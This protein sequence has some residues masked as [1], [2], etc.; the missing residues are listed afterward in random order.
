M[1]SDNMRFRGS[2]LNISLEDGNDDLQIKNDLKQ[3]SKMLGQQTSKMTVE[4]EVKDANATINVDADTSKAEKKIKKA[5]KEAEKPIKP[6]VELDLPLVG[7]KSIPSSVPKQ[8]TTDVKKYFDNINKI[9]GNIIS[10]SQKSLNELQNKNANIE[11]FMSQNP[12]NEAK[13]AGAVTEFLKENNI[14]DDRREIVSTQFRYGNIIKQIDNAYKSGSGVFEMP[15]NLSFSDVTSR[16]Q[17]QADVIAFRDKL[18]TAFLEGNT[19]EN[20]SG[21]SAKE[22]GVVVKQGNYFG[23]KSTELFPKFKS[24]VTDEISQKAMVPE[25]ASAIESGQG[26]SDALSEAK[27]VIGNDVTKIKNDVKK[28]AND[29]GRPKKK[30]LLETNAGAQAIKTA[31]GEVSKAASGETKKITRTLRDDYTPFLS[32]LANGTWSDEDDAALGEGN[33]HTSLSFL[34]QSKF[35]GAYLTAK[36]YG[37]KLSDYGIKDGPSVYEQLLDKI[38]ENNID[39][40]YQAVRNTIESELDSADVPAIEEKAAKKA[41]KTSPKKKTSTPSK[42]KSTSSTKKKSTGTSTNESQPTTSSQTPKAPRIKSNSGFHEVKQ[43]ADDT[44]DAIDAVSSNMDKA[45]DSADKLAEQTQNTANTQEEA[46]KVEKD[47]QKEEEKKVSRKEEPKV[48]KKENEG[49]TEGN[50]PRSDTESQNPRY[51]LFNPEDLEIV[52][53]FISDDRKTSVYR[54]KKVGTLYTRNFVKDDD[55]NWWQ[56]DNVKMN[57]AALE[58]EAVKIEK[59]LMS[60]RE[61]LADEQAKSERNRS[62]A[63]INTST[64]K[65][66]QLERRKRGLRITAEA[67]AQEDPMHYS[68]EQ[69]DRAVQD[70]VKLHKIDM[71]G[72]SDLRTEKS[73]AIVDE[74]TQAVAQARELDQVNKS[75]LDVQ[76]QIDDKSNVGV[77]RIKLKQDLLDLQNQRNE[78]KKNLSDFQSKNFV[79]ANKDVLEANGK[80]VTAFDDAMRRAEKSS[81]KLN[82]YNYDQI[83]SQYIELMNGLSTLEQKNKELASAKSKGSSEDLVKNLQ[84]EIKQKEDSLKDID[85][86]IYQNENILGEDRVNALNTQKSRVDQSKQSVA[87]AFQKP[88]L[89]KKTADFDSQYD[90]A[91]EKVRELKQAYV[92]LYSIQANAASGKYSKDE[93]IE[94]LN[95]QKNKI[96]DIKKDVDGFY[97]QIYQKN[98]S[99]PNDILNSKK[100]EAYEKAFNDMSEYTTYS[101]KNNNIIELMKKAYTNKR[102]NENS[103]LSLAGK[104]DSSADIAIKRILG[105]NYTA[106]YMSLRKQVESIFGKDIA[107]SAISNIRERANLKQDDVVNNNTDSFINQIDSYVEKFEKA[108]RASD[109][110]KN[111]FKDISSAVKEAQNVFSQNRNSDGIE[112]YTDEMQ[113]QVALFLDTKDFY[114]NGF[115]KN[116]LDFTEQLNKM[117]KFS[118]SGN[119]ISAYTNKLNGFLVNYNNIIE[120]LNGKEINTEEAQSQIQDLVKEMQEFQKKSSGYETTN[121]KGTIFDKSFGSIHDIDDATNALRQYANQLGL[122]NEISS[123]INK[124]TGS[125][126]LTFKDASGSLVTLT[127]NIEKAN[128][129]LRTMEKYSNKNATSGFTSLSDSLKGLVKGNF[130]TAIG[131]VVSAVGNIQIMQRAMQEMREGF[132]TFMDY[133]KALTT[134]S[135]TMDMNKQQL[136]S[137]GSSAVD[138]AKDLSMSLE[139]T[140]DIYQIYANMNTTSQEIQETAKPTAILSNLSGV[141]ASTAADQVQG[142]LQQFHMLEDGSTSAAD[143]SMHI[144]D[145]LDKIS[146]NVGIDYAKGIKVI[147]DAVQA[148]GQV[149]YDAGMTYEQLAAIS[150]KVAE[151]TREDGSSIGNALKT[152]ITRTTKVGKMPQYA[153][154]VDNATLSNASASLHAVGVD[155]YNPDGSDRGIVTVLS[156]LKSKWDQLSDA[157]QAKIAFDVAATRLKV[158]LCMKKFILA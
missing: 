140:M 26:I 30:T 134:I 156:E 57:Y 78:L 49:K 18:V 112:K 152:I 31:R 4:M 92:D 22:N 70:G 143:A 109:I 118:N 42:K 65:I 43:K 9:I 44:A 27:K 69:F 99:N 108:G 122:T 96:N 45:V 34:K 67:Y 58:K 5:R 154:E 148:S 23:K 7:T 157:Q 116:E 38:I 120:K 155:V 13:I 84:N 150:A 24:N 19:P 41:S 135:Y 82:S 145:V 105:E 149:A 64:E 86:F 129:S 110:F 100:L 95:N 62:Q 66:K 74:Y 50:I 63:K 83:I 6:P 114:E 133:D 33:K 119:K 25:I 91:I 113:K 56:S 15:G 126:S 147:S 146:G 3:I 1:A 128:D 75:I 32:K 90:S 35:I 61:N 103:I 51:A 73:P 11:N 8:T 88:D 94:K 137:L 101:G 80:D 127:G 14:S 102:N 144:V 85:D 29:A 111:K 17:M 117:M 151:R 54:D 124:S 89:E 132:S 139:N 48:E 87:D 142:I 68:T 12:L 98:K 60:E 158:G 47:I 28:Q 36:K 79:E 136:S 55:G 71:Q 72:R 53:D 97:S 106:S 52:S 81:S 104:G 21:K 123:S 115:G 93:L 46:A 125:V 138:M 20:I 131:D 76:K 2:K 121:S 40:I 107:E 77:D 59:E 10:N 130:T 37:L 16:K 141:D 39:G 153:D